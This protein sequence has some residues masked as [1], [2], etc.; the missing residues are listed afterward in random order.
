MNV[1]HHFQREKSVRIGNSSRLLVSTPIIHPNPDL[2]CITQMPNIMRP[3]IEN[4]VNV[5]SDGN[6]GLWVIARHMDMKVRKTQEG[7]LNCVCFFF[8]FSY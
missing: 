3:Y 2:P 1:S 7:G 4:I 6:F 5:K 8:V